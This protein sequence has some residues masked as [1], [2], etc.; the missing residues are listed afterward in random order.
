MHRHHHRHVAP[1]VT[2]I[3]PQQEAESGDQLPSVIGQAEPTL[4]RREPASSE[5]HAAKSTCHGKDCGDGSSTTTAT[6]PVVLGAVY[7]AIVVLGCE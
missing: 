5:S 2:G 1:V 6:L 4:V 7:V 3:Q